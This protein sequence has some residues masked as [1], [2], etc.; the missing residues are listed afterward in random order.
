MLIRKIIIVILSFYFYDPKA[1]FQKKLAPAF[2]EE[3][4]FSIEKKRIRKKE[5][6]K[7]RA[8]KNSKWKKKKQYRNKALAFSGINPK[9]NRF[10]NQRTLRRMFRNC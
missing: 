1:R 8:Y 6:K 9:D 4:V 10:S 3:I 5:K 7:E 2:L